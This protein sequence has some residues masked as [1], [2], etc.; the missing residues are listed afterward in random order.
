MKLQIS[1]YNF[2]YLNSLQASQLS[3]GLVWENTMELPKG[4]HYGELGCKWTTRRPLSLRSLTRRQVTLRRYH[5]VVLSSLSGWL[6]IICEMKHHHHPGCQ[7]NAFISNERGI[8]GSPKLGM[9]R[10]LPWCPWSPSIVNCQKL[11]SI[12][13]THT[14]P[15]NNNH[16]CPSSWGLGRSPR[17]GSQPWKMCSLQK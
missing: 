6:I 12:S 16:S 8:H 2:L 10:F 15:Q 7:G 11:L 14:K 3:V 17:A 5:A 1:E 13:N 9:K 4:E